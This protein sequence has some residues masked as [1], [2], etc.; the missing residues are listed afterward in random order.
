MNLTCL[1]YLNTK[2]KQIFDKKFN[3]LIYLFCSIGF[4]FHQLITAN[5]TFIFSLIPILCAYFIIQLKDF[6]ILK[7]KI[8]IFYNLYFVCYYKI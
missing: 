3:K 2:K 4:I 1:I 7:I 5:Q 8:N 6:L